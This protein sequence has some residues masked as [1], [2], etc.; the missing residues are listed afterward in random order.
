MKNLNNI[1]LDPGK[2]IPQE[3]LINLS[4]GVVEECIHLTC[5]GSVGEWYGVYENGGELNAAVSAYCTTG[6]AEMEMAYGM[7]CW[8]IN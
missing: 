6:Q 2:L 3:Q 1:G 5:I 8:G 4:G 7:D